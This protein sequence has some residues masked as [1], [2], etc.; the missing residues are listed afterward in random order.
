MDFYLSGDLQGFAKSDYAHA[1][2]GKLRGGKYVARIQRGTDDDGKPRY[3]YFN[4]VDEYRAYLSG[5]G[6]HKNKDRASEAEEKK[7]SEGDGS[8]GSTEGKKSS[9]DSKGLLAP[10]K[11]SST[12]KSLR[13]FLEQ[14]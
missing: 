14:K 4:D 2:S 13:L 8:E 5:A 11:S 6:R 10:K 9:K 3:R 12:K 1:E 7:D